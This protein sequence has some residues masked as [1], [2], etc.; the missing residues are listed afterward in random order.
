LTCRSRLPGLIDKLLYIGRI[1]SRRQ[2]T[3][4]AG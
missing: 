3:S 2:T 4:L 1:K